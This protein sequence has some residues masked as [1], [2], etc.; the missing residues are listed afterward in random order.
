MAAAVPAKSMASEPMAEAVT[1]MPSAAESKGDNRCTTVIVR[2][3]IISIA[4]VVGPI[5]AM[6]PVTV[7]V[8]PMVSTPGAE[9]S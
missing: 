9:V 3:A 4:S 1:T 2:R 7:V 8:A 5:M 6:A